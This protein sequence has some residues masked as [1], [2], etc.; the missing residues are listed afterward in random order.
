M[1]A[2]RN[3]M[4]EGFGLCLLRIKTKKDTG[5]GHGSYLSSS[6]RSKQQAARDTL[7]ATPYPL[8]S[9]P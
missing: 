9:T 6:S 2:W 5:E 1:P 4:R 3:D 8:P 7:H